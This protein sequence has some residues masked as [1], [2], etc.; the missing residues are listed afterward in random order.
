MIADCETCDRKQVPCKSCQESQRA[1][2]FICQGDSDPD[3][4]RELCACS[5]GCQG[6]SN[7]RF[8]R[9]DQLPV[10]CDC[11]DEKWR[12]CPVCS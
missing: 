11:P 4:Y 6:A 2:C 12:N 1:V 8:G 7:C 10:D 5:W 3:P 9:A